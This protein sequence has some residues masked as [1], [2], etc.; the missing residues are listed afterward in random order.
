MTWGWD[1]DHQSYEFSVGVWI[2]RGN[3]KQISWDTEVEQQ[4]NVFFILEIRYFKDAGAS[5]GGISIH[6]FS[7]FE[8][9]KQEQHGT[10]TIHFATL[11]PHNNR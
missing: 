8:G 9:H 3:E 1:E 6:S 11:A 5:W 7:F 10:A 4:S 2:L